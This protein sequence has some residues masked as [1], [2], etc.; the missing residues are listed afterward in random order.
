M[1][2]DTKNIIYDSV[3][4]IRTHGKFNGSII[5]MCKNENIILT[6]SLVY[7]DNIIEIN[8]GLMVG[9]ESILANKKE[10]F[11]ISSNFRF[12]LDEDTIDYSVLIPEDLVEK[13][14][15]ER[16]SDAFPY[17]INLLHSAGL[18]LNENHL[19]MN[20]LD[21]FKGEILKN[22]IALIHNGI[23]VADRVVI[24][25]S[26]NPIFYGTLIIGRNK[27]ENL[28]ISY[29]SIVNVSDKLIRYIIIIGIETIKE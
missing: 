7:Y 8:K 28:S 11:S 5:V 1:N 29:E 23:C 25:E 16:F 24:D 21:F 9:F 20:H 12:N 4:N 14:D 6:D 26:S 19:G 10:A 15:K 18:L 3:K 22:P 13:F 27:K 2:L 17:T